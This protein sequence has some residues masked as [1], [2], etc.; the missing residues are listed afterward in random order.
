VRDVVVWR[1]VTPVA[2]AT[3]AKPTTKKAHRSRILLV[4]MS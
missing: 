2:P 3:D 1:H 4:S